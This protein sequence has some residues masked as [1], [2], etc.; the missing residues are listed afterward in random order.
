[1]RA[2]EE[3]IFDLDVHLIPARGG[4]PAHYHYDVR[5]LVQAMGERFR[6]SEKSCA[7][8]WMPADRV[9]V[10]TNGESV[11]HMGRKW[12]ARRGGP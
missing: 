3:T 8:A 4:E 6:V 10:F 5:F 2:L 11:V 9:A 1:M 7:L 12:W